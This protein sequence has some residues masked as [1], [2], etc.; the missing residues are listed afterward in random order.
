MGGWCG[1]HDL[2]RRNGGGLWMVSKVALAMFVDEEMD[3]L[4]QYH[5]G[6]AEVDQVHFPL[7]GMVS[8]VVAMRD[9]RAI[10][11][12]TAGRVGVVGARSGLSIHTTKVRAIAQLPTFAIKVAAKA[13]KKTVAK[14]KP[15]ANLCVRYNEVLLAQARVTAACNALRQVEARFCRW[16]LQTSDR[17]ESDRITY[18]GV[19]RWTAAIA[20]ISRQL[21]NRTGPG[22]LLGPLFKTDPR[23]PQCRRQGGT[24]PGNHIEGSRNCRHWRRRHLGLPTGYFARTNG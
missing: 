17:A 21:L 19:P 6:N 10:E 11:T 3:V 9:G 22:C 4:A 2:G 15:I 23:W 12:A 20:C 8:M 24:N 16:L 1:E 14:S 18:T 13:L 5:S 7:S